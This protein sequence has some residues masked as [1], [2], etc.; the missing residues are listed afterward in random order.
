MGTTYRH[1][2]LR[3]L[4]EQQARFAPKERRLEQIDRAERLLTETDPDKRYPY[5]YLVFPAGAG[6]GPGAGWPRRHP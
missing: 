2:A 6:A 5:E 1:P 4:K 3:Q